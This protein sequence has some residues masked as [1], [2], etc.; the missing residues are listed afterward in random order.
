MDI[1]VIPGIARLPGGW[2][3]NVSNKGEPEMTEK[4]TAVQMA[5]E[6]SS[7]KVVEP[8][9]LFERID[10]IH[11]NIAR[12]AFEIF[13]NDGGLFG[14]A[15]D[16]WLK[17]EA[18]LLHPVHVNIT[19]SDDALSVQVEVPGFDAN[20]LE[21]SLE[22]RRL[23]ISGKKETSKEDKKKGKII[24]KEQC[25]TEILR[26]IDLPA[27]VDAENATATLKNGVLA[28]TLPNDPQAKTTRVEVKAA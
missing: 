23:T 22:P 16:H 1:V 14:H 27:Q 7:L 2:R 24:Y 4:S 15:L 11:R 5:P 10:Q 17:A 25:S 18:E 20:E 12:R 8:K 6:P 19:G 3:R 26:I 13:Q 28:L 9:T 21:V